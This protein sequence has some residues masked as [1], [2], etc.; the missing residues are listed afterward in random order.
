MLCGFIM[1]MKYKPAWSAYLV[2]AMLVFPGVAALGVPAGQKANAYLEVF[3]KKPGTLLNFHHGISPQYR[4]IYRS[5]RFLVDEAA[6]PGKIYVFGDPLHYYLSGRESALPIIGW[7][8]GYFL[9]SQWFKLPAQL[10]AARPPYIYVDK[11]NLRYMGFRG[12]GVLKFIEAH[13]TTLFNDH[14]GTW[15]GAKPKSWDD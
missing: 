8:W 2:S 9:Q 3:I 14:E 1:D 15:W 11:R 7:P 13:Y 4:M 12:G 5:T 6:R 10:E